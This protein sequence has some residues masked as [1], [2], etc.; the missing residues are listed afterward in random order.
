MKRERER[1]RERKEK[2]TKP[3][4]VFKYNLFIRKFNTKWLKIKKIYSLTHV[5]SQ[6][7]YIGFFIKC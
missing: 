1:E 4:C 6:L 3:H 2:T 5:T 7:L